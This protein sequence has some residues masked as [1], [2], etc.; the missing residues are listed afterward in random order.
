VEPVQG[1]ARLAAGGVVIFVGTVL[2]LLCSDW[3][4]NRGE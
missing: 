3:W 1:L 2:A 4:R